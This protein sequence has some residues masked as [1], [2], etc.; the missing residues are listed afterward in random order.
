MSTWLI[1]GSSSGLGRDLARAVIEA[2]HNAVLSAR[3]PGSV[4][5][6]ADAHPDT[7]LM[8]GQPVR[9]GVLGLAG[10]A[11]SRRRDDR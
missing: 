5:D 6:L 2:G 7:A 8:G 3:D 10:C 1:T 4:K 9:A 11:S